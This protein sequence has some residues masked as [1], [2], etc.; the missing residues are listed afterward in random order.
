MK[1]VAT[2]LVVSRKACIVD[3]DVSDRYRG[4]RTRAERKRKEDR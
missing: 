1:I 4:S 3:E 2:T